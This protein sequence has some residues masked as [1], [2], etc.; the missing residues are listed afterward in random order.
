MQSLLL[1][2]MDAFGCGGMLSNNDE[3]ILKET[4]SSLDRV[5]EA[6][7]KLAGYVTAETTA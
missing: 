6:T 2:L 4:H 1:R 5:G 3:S 7:R